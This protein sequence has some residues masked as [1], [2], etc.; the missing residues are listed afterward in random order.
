MDE[1]TFQKATRTKKE[2]EK[3]NPTIYTLK[4]GYT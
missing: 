1:M 3:P 2:K 4:Q